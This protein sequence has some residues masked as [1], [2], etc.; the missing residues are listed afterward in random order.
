MT[1]ETF[2]Y[3]GGSAVGERLEVLHVTKTDS[4]EID[5]RVLKH[6]AKLRKLKVSLQKKKLSSTGR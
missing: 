2:E 3:L 1:E 6:I 5:E 4:N